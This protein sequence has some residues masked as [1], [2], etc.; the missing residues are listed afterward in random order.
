M[1]AKPIDSSK[2]K[3]TSAEEL[4][5]QLESSPD[6]LSPAAAAE[7]LEVCGPNALEEK[8]TSAWIKFLRY[9]WGPIPWMI[10]VA[11]ILSLVLMDW[12]DFFIIL[13]LLLFNAVL[14]FWE[15]SRAANALAA[16][17][18]HLALKARVKRGEWADVPAADLV[19]G[20]VIR[21][22]LGEIVPADLKLLE[23]DFVSI[24][25]AA[26]TGESL[27]VTMHAGDI[28]YSG[29]V[30]KQGEMTG[31]VT[32]TGGN[33]FFGRT[34]ALVESA[35]AVSHFQQAVLRIGN[36]LIVFAGVLSVLLVIVELSRDEPFLDLLQFVLILVIAAIPVA[37]PAVLSVT[38][39]LGAFQLSKRK[40]IVS[41]LQSIE[42][43]AGIDI[44][45]S[46]KT[47]TLTQNKISLGEPA[48]VFAAR[49]PA[50]L[51]L[52]AAL[53]SQSGNDDVID[54]AVLAGSGELAA[55]G[56]Y[57]QTKFVPFDPVKKRTEA[58]IEAPDGQKFHVSK[59]A[60]QVMLDLCQVDANTRSRAEKATTDLAGRGLRTLG[61]ARS[62]KPDQWDFLGLLT[63]LDPPRE[64]SAETIRQAKAHGIDV[65]MVTGD[66]VPVACE[67][68]RQLGLGDHIQAADRLFT[69][70]V[71]PA[72]LSPA[73]AVHIEKADGFAQVF[74]EHKYGIVKA[75][76]ER[77]H[78]VAMTGD[79]VN[80]SPA[81][82]QA[83]AGVA[84][85]GATDAARA[86]A[87]LV[88]T[89]PG[90]SVIIDAVEEAR[91]IFERMMSYT[92]YRIAITINITLFV[93]LSICLFNYTPLTP[94]M[95]VALALLDD[96][97]IM[98][99]AYDNARVSPKPV[100]WNMGQVLTT[101]IVLG[102]IAVAQAIGLLYLGRVVW[103]SVPELQQWIPMDDQHLQTA[104]FL[105]L[106]LGGHL[107]LFVTR[108]KSFFFLPPWPSW[109]LFGAIMG[110]QLFAAL[111]CGFG[112]FVPAL[113][114][115]I[116]GLVW[117]YNLAWMLIQ[118]VVKVALYH[119]LHHREAHQRGFLHHLN[120]RLHPYGQA[121]G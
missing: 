63:L 93:V 56:Q 46:D 42:E 2:A 20:D 80:D 28:A 29:S 21:I 16:L 32:G 101:S 73:A 84:V 105:Q 48:E 90:L 6:G 71:D 117:A 10:E 66:N 83:D 85:A 91:R 69:K 14:G 15:E 74:P 54:K 108:A 39:A 116:T 107:M 11:A 24:D 23:G 81:L 111:M 18:G 44:L 17:K 87:D 3:Q 30:V 104:L 88:L 35:G 96:I 1:D 40:A 58:L 43:M 99:I 49:D 5:R 106:V 31:L 62:T 55:Y 120:Q 75:L 77:G 110:T 19:P 13:F 38:M 45:C 67:I 78:L 89:A 68:S 51:L 118:D 115:A 27:P 9:F 95:I 109:Q 79:G 98:T 59:G 82:K 112:W 102:A 4:F 22:R 57:N 65:K 60:P 119:H 64:D 50:D 26:L 97:P 94:L 61:V 121:H 34:A 76:Q 53:A 72:H 113:P 100:R 103:T 8:K 47:G 70:D 86:A 41:R 92:I 25:Q 36:F 12:P 52:A 7:R 114:W 33:T 37:M